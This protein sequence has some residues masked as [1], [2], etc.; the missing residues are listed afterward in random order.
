MIDAR[1][2]LELPSGASYTYH[3]LPQLEKTGVGT[4]SRLPVSLRILLE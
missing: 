2:R 3:S 1:R 4:I